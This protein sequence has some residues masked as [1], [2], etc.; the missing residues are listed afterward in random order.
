MN[1]HP[2]HANLHTG[3]TP[4]GPAADQGNNLPPDRSFLQR[5]WHTPGFVA[6][7]AIFITSA[8]IFTGMAI[9]GMVPLAVAGATILIVAALC[10]PIPVLIAASKN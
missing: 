9:G 3:A 7:S 2:I 10:F 6:L 4:A 1:T 5:L 8:V